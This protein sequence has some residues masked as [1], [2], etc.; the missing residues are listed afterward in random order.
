MNEIKIISIRKPDLQAVRNGV[1]GQEL[2]VYFSVNGKKFKCDYIQEHYF[3]RGL[4]GIWHE[5]CNFAK[6]EEGEAK[7]VA[8]CN[9]EFKIPHDVPFNENAYA[10]HNYNGDDPKYLEADDAIVLKY[11]V[12]PFVETYF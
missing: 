1:A 10:D 12:E 4:P 11:L 6:I 7:H 3:Y 2:L 8:C 9:G 5:S